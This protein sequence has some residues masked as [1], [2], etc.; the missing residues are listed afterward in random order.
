MLRAARVLQAVGLVRKYLNL[1][2]RSGSNK[3]E[4]WS[5]GPHN[6][7]PVRAPTGVHTY[8]VNPGPMAGCSAPCL[9]HSG[10]YYPLWYLLGS[11]DFNGTF[12]N[13]NCPAN[14]STIKKPS[15]CP[16]L[17]YETDLLARHATSWLRNITAQEPTR[18]FFACEYRSY[19]S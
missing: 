5:P 11:P 12:R 17:L 16:G 4:P 13:G 18:P 15:D 9:D 6:S 10:E 1:S 3:P 14:T 8:F 19:C 2:P 7:N